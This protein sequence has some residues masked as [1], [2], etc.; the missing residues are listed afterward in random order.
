MPKS[1]GVY[2]FRNKSGKVVYVGKARSLRDRVSSYFGPN[3]LPK[4][5]ALVAEIAK[6]DHIVV[7]SEVDALLL[8]A[9]QI[10]KLKPHYN[11]TGKDGKNFPYIE[12]TKDKIP[13]VKIVRYETGF[14]PY[15]PGSDIQS[16]L[17]YLRRIFPYVSERHTNNRPCLRS[18]LG[19]CPCPD[20]RNYLQDLKHL[21]DFL[22]GK[23]KSVIKNL[24][25]EMQ[26][27]A[28]NQDF[29]KA[30]EIKNKLNQMNYISSAQYRP[31]QYEQNPNLVSDTHSNEVSELQKI[32]N[33]SVLEKIEAYDISNTAGKQ[34]TGAGIA[35]INGE[36]EKKLYRRYRIKLKSSP[37]DYAMLK[38]VL[39]R[40][41]KSDVPLPDLFVIDGG[42]GQVSAARQVIKNIP[43]IGLAKKLETIVTDHGEINL[44]ENSPALHL[45]QRMRDEAHRFSRKYHFL[46]RSRKM[47][48]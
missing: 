19:L 39:A 11:I 33:I 34:G 45:L 13:L 26:S 5:A 15:P 43:V 38:E 20:Y 9:N 6:I 44:P 16:L 30:A 28:Q 37:D 42:T 7:E 4:T 48:Q 8:E 17:R 32:L 1:P 21:K 18:H 25:K 3:L 24:E 41:L 2:F 31:W 23:R 35:F 22:M 47:L 40:R 36:P 14:G 10:R 27:A 29:E 12:I 46:L